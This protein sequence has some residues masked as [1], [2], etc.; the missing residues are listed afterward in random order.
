M[1]SQKKRGKPHKAPKRSKERSRIRSNKYCRGPERP[2]SHVC[3]YVA[4]RYLEKKAKKQAEAHK[5]RDR[6]KERQRNTNPDY[7][8]LEGFENV[9][10]E[11]SKYLGGEISRTHLV[12]GLDEAL[13]QK[14]R[15][16][17]EREAEEQLER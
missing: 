1:I 8:D 7:Q 16:E 14:V 11:T 17:Q 12:K 15:E 4:S 2:P 3:T 9:D 13:L 5:Y 10:A 6:A